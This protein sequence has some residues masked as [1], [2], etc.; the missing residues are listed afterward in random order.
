[1][2]QRL[3]FVGVSTAASGIMTIFPEWAKSL[4][5]SAGMHGVDLPVGARPDDV[6]SA[7]DA[8]AADPRA[9]GALV[10]THKAS[11]WDAA[12]DRF[13]ALD[14]W[15]QRCREISCIAVRDGALTGWAKDPITVRQAYT[16]LL[17][18]DPWS[19]GGRDVVCLGAGGAG[20]ALAA[21]VL[22]GEDQPRRVVLADRDPRR[23]DVSR[24]VLEQLDV[25]AALE[26]VVVR[27]T[28]DAGALVS[29]SAEGSLVVNAT[30]MGKDLPGSPIGH[31]AAFPRGAVAWDMNYRGDLEFL[32]IAEAQAQDRA[33]VVSD[34]W[35]YFLHGWTE[36]VAELFG[37]EMTPEV[38]AELASIAGR[39]SGGR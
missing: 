10:T 32:R 35:R 30:G 2:P 23:L 13:A 37:I 28:D 38:F 14:P 15:A 24:E 25:R 1:M 29:G 36:V 8:L 27:D 31:D 11:V 4:G 19:D 12:A 17:G 18:D 3:Y 22:E 26:L 5:L 34:G 6:R 39:V 20:L 7:V 33:L 16:H 9:V 21:A